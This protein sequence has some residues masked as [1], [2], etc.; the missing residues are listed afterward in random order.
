MALIHGIRRKGLFSMRI[1]LAILG[2]AI[3][4]HPFF[5]PAQAGGSR[6]ETKATAVSEGTLAPDFAL[7]NLQGKT[8][9]LASYRGQVV[10]VNFWATWCP[11]C[12]EEMPSMEKLQALMAGEKFVML[13]INVEEDGEDNV[14]HFLKKHPHTFPIL[15]DTEAEVQA[16]YGVYRFP[17]TFVIGKDGVITDHII[18]A[19]DWAAEDTVKYFKTLVGR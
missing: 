1:S 18:G 16:R 6:P 7:K 13:A 17:E 15:L 9:D 3:F 12:L 8:V 10:L 14:L 19:I 11:P 5:S 2:C 4:L